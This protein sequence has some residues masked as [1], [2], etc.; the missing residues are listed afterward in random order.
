MVERAGWTGTKESDLIKRS[1]N[2][3]G[4]ISDSPTWVV[5]LLHHLPKMATSMNAYG[6]RSSNGKL[7]ASF[8]ILAV[9]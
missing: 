4:A 5:L 1:Q 8:S 3:V 7:I 6:S 9:R 2:Q